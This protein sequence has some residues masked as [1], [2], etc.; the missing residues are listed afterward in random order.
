MAV[1]E[2]AGKDGWIHS[3]LKK[4]I[5]YIQDPAKTTSPE[6]NLL[7]SNSMLIKPNADDET[8]FFFERF[9]RNP[10]NR[11]SNNRLAAHF[12]QSFPEEDEK[13]LTPEQVHELGVQLAEKMT[14]GSKHFIVAT[15]VS[16]AHIHNHIL[17]VNHDEITGRSWKWNQRDLKAWRDMNDRISL[18]NSLSV[19]PPAKIG[20]EPEERDLKRI[21]ERYARAGGRSRLEQLRMII[22]TTAMNTSTFT[23]LRKQ[24]SQHNIQIQNRGKHFTYIYKG[25]KLRDNRLGEA[26]TPQNLFAR[27][28]KTTVFEITINK[29]LIINKNKDTVTVAL[30]GTHGKL[31]LTIPQTQTVSDGTTLRAY[32]AIHRELI[33]LTKTGQL[34]HKITGEELQNYFTPTQERPSITRVSN[35]DGIQEIMK[36]TNHTAQQEISMQKQIDEVRQALAIITAYDPQ[37]QHL[38][39]TQSMIQRELTTYQHELMKIVVQETIPLNQASPEEQARAWDQKNQKITALENKIQE[40]QKRL[41][42]LNNVAKHVQERNNHRRNR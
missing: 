14:G 16:Q 10:R 31:R 39:V 32:I 37:T 15:H 4:A 21:G 12:V 22:D 23:E 28:Q 5:Q 20:Y 29:R 7:I 8:A 9:S 27:L 33:L 38:S 17:I 2:Y 11:K 34:D 40:D 25:V 36:A 19:L 13:K 3:T 26:F 6:G 1:L 42:L 24:L 18:E 35:D 30:P 41:Q